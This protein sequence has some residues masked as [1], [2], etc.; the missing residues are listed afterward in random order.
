MPEIE[1]PQP[2]LPL[3]AAVE[4]VRVRGALPLYRHP[5]WPSRFPW[6]FQGVT[7]RGEGA[8]PEDFSPFRGRG[9][10]SRARKAAADLRR[11]EALPAA[12][13]FDSFVH[14]GRL[15]GTEIVVHDERRPGL[16]LLPAADGHATAVPGLLLAQAVADCVPIYLAD[17]ERRAVALLHGGWRGI[18]AGI[19][20]RAVE[21]LSA[22]F[23]TR[24]ERLVL[25][26]GPAICGSCYEVGPEVHAALG[27]EAPPR[28]APVDLR[29]AAARRGLAAGMSRE[30]IT[31]SSFCTRCE[32]SPFL[33]H[34]RGDRERQIALLGIRPER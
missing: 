23:R 22:R 6:L 21:L 10:A 4:E 32:G 27:L 5:R 31:A 19:L 34:R 24:R 7:W 12:T 2:E 29:H 18:A 33:S 13:G 8:S 16:L 17:E 9:E 15:H 14:G 26:L 1:H 3:P 28:P 11:W 30:R 25:H 20:E